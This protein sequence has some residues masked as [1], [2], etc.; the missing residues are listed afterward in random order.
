MPLPY[1]LLTGNQSRHLQSHLLCPLPLSVYPTL[2]D[3]LVHEAY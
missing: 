2:A 1:V 3:V